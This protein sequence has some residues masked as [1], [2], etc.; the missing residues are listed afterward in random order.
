VRFICVKETST[1]YSPARARKLTLKDLI[2]FNEKNSDQ[3]MP[4]FGQDVLYSGAAKGDLNDRAIALL[5]F[6]QL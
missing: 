2:A 4:Y 6:Q 5:C 3:E 1:E